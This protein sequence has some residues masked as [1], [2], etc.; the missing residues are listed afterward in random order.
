[1]LLSKIYV[2]W[3]VAVMKSPPL[4]RVDYGHAEAALKYGKDPREYG[5]M[6]KRFI[7]DKATGAVTGVEIV[8]VSHHGEW[9]CNWQVETRR[10]RLGGGARRWV[11]LPEDLY[12]SWDEAC[13][14]LSLLP[15]PRNP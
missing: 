13:L 1:M 11:C 8:N 9:V 6:T 7:G 15:S 3:W 4:P 5:V 12:G 14:G 10:G 2:G